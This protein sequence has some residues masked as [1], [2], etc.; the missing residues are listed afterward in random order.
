MTHDSSI[1]VLSRGNNLSPEVKRRAGEGWEGREGLGVFFFLGKHFLE[2]L[3][4]GGPLLAK[5]IE[6]KPSQPSLIG[7]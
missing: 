3:F 7:N 4:F 5:K 2:K 1:L 6:T